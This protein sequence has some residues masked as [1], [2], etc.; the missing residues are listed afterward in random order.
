[1]GS[2]TQAGVPSLEGLCSQSPSCHGQ[3]GCKGG[4]EAQ[5]VPLSCQ[6]Y[7]QHQSLLMTM[8]TYHTIARHDTHGKQ[9]ARC[10]CRESPGQLGLPGC[11]EALEHH[12][13]KHSDERKQIFAQMAV[14]T[15]YDSVAER[16]YCL[17]VLPE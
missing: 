5:Q 14:L 8:L 4:L 7:F 17:S 3:A 12:W 11:V 2:W 9:Y 13:D 6:H 10:A 15:R 16:L 1:M